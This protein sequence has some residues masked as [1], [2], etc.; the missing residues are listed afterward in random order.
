MFYVVNK[1]FTSRK[2]V[3]W[4]LMLFRGMYM[5]LVSWHT[6]MACL[7]LNVPLPTSCPLIRILKPVITFIWIHK[8][9]SWQYQNQKIPKFDL[10]CFLLNADLGRGVSRTPRPL[11]WTSPTWSPLPTCLTGPKFTNEEQNHHPAASTWGKDDTTDATETIA[12][13]VRGFFRGGCVAGFA[14]GCPQIWLQQTAT[15]EQGHP[16]PRCW[17]W[18][19]APPDPPSGPAG[20]WVEGCTGSC[21]PACRWACRSI[22]TWSHHALLRSSDPQRSAHLSSS[23]GCFCGICEDATMCQLLYWFFW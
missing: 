14:L 10:V 18:P 22:W 1:H 8:S 5:S 13:P 6:T 2:P 15:E 23:Q 7:W 12:I 3:C 16:C 4:G 11:L 9:I 19:K 17:L 21:W 20:W